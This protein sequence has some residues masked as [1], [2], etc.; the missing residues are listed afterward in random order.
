MGVGVLVVS[1]KKPGQMLLVTSR[2]SKTWALA[3]GQIDP[4]LG[5]LESARR[6]AFEEAGV[7]GR[8]SSV[9][10][11]SYLHQNS[12]GDVFRIRVFKMH[13]RIELA[14]WP[15][16]EERRRRW[17][18]ARSALKLVANSS[19]RQLIEAQLA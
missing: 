14:K 3:K 15:E 17:I 9:P 18:S 13:V 5:P 4:S 19:L 2:H 16:K 6:E 8:M 7:R 12:A 11:G 1:N 10:I